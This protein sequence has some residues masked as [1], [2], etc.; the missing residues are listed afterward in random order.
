MIPE[1]DVW[2]TAHLLIKQ[3]GEDAAVQ[4]A[5]RAP[6]GEQDAEPEPR[7]QQKQPP[8][9]ARSRVHHAATFGFIGTTLP[10]KPAGAAAMA[11]AI[12]E[13][14]HRSWPRIARSVFDLALG[15]ICRGLV[16]DFFRRF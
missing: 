13:V 2:R 15:C 10:L 5:F 3:H 11:A 1:I 6:S 7:L 14:G 16:R 4:A 9:L 12:S 8:A